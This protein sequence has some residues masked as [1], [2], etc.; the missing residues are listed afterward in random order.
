MVALGAFFVEVF[1]A[2][3]AGVG[4]CFGVFYGGGQGDDAGFGFA[5]D[6]G[7][8][9]PAALDGVGALGAFFFLVGFAALLE[10]QVWPGA[11][12]HAD[13]IDHEGHERCYEAKKGGVFKVTGRKVLMNDAHE[14]EEKADGKGVNEDAV[15]GV[16]LFGDEPQGHK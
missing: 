5:G 16:S 8:F 1:A 3:G 2:G 13:E 4:F 15:G 10:E 12:D 9:Q 11:G 7:F 6:A 14:L